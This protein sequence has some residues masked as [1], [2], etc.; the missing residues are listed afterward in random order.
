[1]IQVLDVANRE[2]LARFDAV[3]DV[4]SPSEF[5]EDHVPEA[6]N[7]PVLDD[8]ERALIG[9]IYVQRSRFEARRLG[10][11]I[12][13]R[14]IASHLDNDLS[15]R[16]PGFAPLVY[17]WR[18]GQRS[19][20]MATVLDQVGW[21]PTLLAGGYKTY[22]RTVRARLDETPPCIVLLSGYTGMAKTAML[23]A[24]RSLGAQTIDLE[25]LAHHRGSLLGDIVGEAQPSQKMF[26]SR[27]AVELAALDPSKPALMESESSK[28]GDINIPHAL[29]KAMSSAP[30][31]EVRAS[32]GVRAAYLVSAYQ[33]LT[34]EPDR[35]VA[36][37]AR[38]P[39]RHGRSTVEV[40]RGLARDGQYEALAGALMEAHYDPAYLRWNRTHPRPCIGVIDLSDLSALSIS[41]AAARIV[42]CLDGLGV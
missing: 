9:T 39:G 31:I 27:L 24:A 26:E 2:A 13:A 30:M 40:W 6:I 4:R 8:D 41:L 17:C 11:A 36:A 33:D 38:L 29:W 14:N 32:T 21:R 5:A 20:A 16:P 42:R 19:A 25:R 10:A 28:I 22:R 35:L 3:I 7:L 15:A 1:V 34:S 23:S 18:G 12:V 37:L